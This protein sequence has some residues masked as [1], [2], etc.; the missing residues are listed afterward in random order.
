MTRNVKVFMSLFLVFALLSVFAT[1]VWAE[2]TGETAPVVVTGNNKSGFYAYF[3]GASE[4]TTKFDAP[5]GEALSIRIEPAAGYQI[6]AVKVFESTSFALTELTSDGNSVYTIDSIV[7]GG[8]Y[9]IQVTT[10]FVGLPE[11]PSDDPSQDSSTEEPSDDP[12][13]D[14]STEEPSD[15]PSQ[16]T[17]TEEPSDDPSEDTSSEDTSSEDTS[18]EAPK[19]TAELKVTIKGAGSVTVGS[20]TITSEGGQ[21]DHSM[22]L[23]VGVIN[24]VTFAP[25]LGYRMVSL[26]LDGQNRSL[27]DSMNLRITEYTTL[28]VEYAPG[29]VAPTNYQILI[30]CTNAGGF[31]SA[32]GYTITS[33]QTLT[34]SAGESLVIVVNP[35]EG[36]QVDSFKVGGTAQNLKDN[37]FVLDNIV[38]NATIS[39]SFKAVVTQINPIEAA[40]VDWTPHDGQIVID[41]T[42]NAYVG[43]SVFDKINTLTSADADYV[44]FKTNSIRWMIP[45]G[46]IVSGVAN[47]YVKMSVAVGPN[48]S[49]YEALKGSLLG[50]Y[51]QAIFQY[52]ELA[53]TIDMPDGTLVSFNLSGY[54]SAAGG[55]KITLWAKV[56]EDGKYKLKLIGAADSGRTLANGWTEPMAYVDSANFF[57]VVK[58]AVTY[59]VEVTVTM[60]GTVSPSGQ[61]TLSEGDDETFEIQANKGYVISAL[62]IN[63]ALQKAAEG[64]EQYTY[65]LSAISADCDIR[66][67]FMQASEYEKLQG[68]SGAEI[69]TDGSDEGGSNVGLIVAIIIIV[70][71]IGGATALFIVKWRQ[72]KF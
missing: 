4:A 70:V 43:K 37:T 15:D 8:N 50:Q 17:S 69:S 56:K 30:S 36:Y 61:L 10:T 54:A 27:A 3:N 18:S 55:D 1:A 35:M 29:T 53:E 12:S 24:P 49:Q 32:G 11:E 26:K 19:N 34:V 21:L 48:G 58:K 5:V 23:E 65:V 63:G 41:L 45:C 68:N 47:A 20:E 46:G 57:T 33:S 16:D 39:I 14:T 31:V 25:A 13:E 38:S 60:G 9:S 7:S 59:T 71:A 67:E 6:D 44:V 62:Y 28:E 42:S 40:D 66:A 52:Y 64:K 72:E 2:P 51:P 22:Q